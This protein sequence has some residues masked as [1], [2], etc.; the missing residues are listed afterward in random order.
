MPVVDLPAGL[1][2]DNSV[3][4]GEDLAE[5]ARRELR[6]ETG[7]DARQM[8]LLTEGPSSAG[9]TSE[10][11]TFFHAEH[12]RKVGDGGGDDSENIQVH[13]VALPEIE[14]WLTQQAA[15]EKWIDPKIYAALFFVLRRNKMVLECDH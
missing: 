14:A 15:Q 9:L 1:A 10:I 6:A 11:V 8:T 4:H 5:A 3:N 13:E 12:S 7:Y 2:G